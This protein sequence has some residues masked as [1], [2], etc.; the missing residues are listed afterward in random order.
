MAGDDLAGALTAANT[1]S[2]FFFG[3]GNDVADGDLAGALA[4][5]DTGSAFLFG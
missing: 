1:G 4:A 5:A 2:V 3:W